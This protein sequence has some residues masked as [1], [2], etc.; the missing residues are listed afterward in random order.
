LASDARM[1]EIEWFVIFSWNYKVF[2][3]VFYRFALLNQASW[4]LNLC[5]RISS[6]GH[7]KVTAI[8][9]GQIRAMKKSDINKRCDN[10]LVDRRIVTLMKDIF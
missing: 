1:S 8:I 2:K 5:A 10:P 3:V 4:S 9:L 6:F 7:C